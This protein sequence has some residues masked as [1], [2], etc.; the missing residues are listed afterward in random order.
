MVFPDTA[1][2]AGIARPPQALVVPARAD[3]IDE[4]VAIDIEREVAER[5][6]IG[7]VFLQ[8]AG[9]VAFPGGVFVP[10]FAGKDIGAAIVVEVADGAGFADAGVDEVALEDEL[11]AARGD[12][13]NEQA[14][15]EGVLTHR[16]ITQLG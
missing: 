2:F 4:A 7:A 9:L 13:E 15:G 3:D 8:M 14:R 10:G 6:E 16:T 1:G 12:A 5:S 11:R